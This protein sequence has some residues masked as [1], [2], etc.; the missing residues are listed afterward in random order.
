MLCVVEFKIIVNAFCLFGRT[1]VDCELN[2]VVMQWLN[3]VISFEFL[4]FLY[5][6]QTS[7][8][9]KKG[10]VTSTSS[11]S[12]T[13]SQLSSPP[14]PVQTS[15]ESCSIEEKRRERRQRRKALA[16]ANSAR[17][18]DDGAAA[19]DESLPPFHGFTPEYVQERTQ[20]TEEGI[21]RNKLI[22]ELLKRRDLTDKQL[23]SI[24]G[25]SKTSWLFGSW[26]GVFCY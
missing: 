16:A 13:D 5:K 26:V 15:V 19:G 21:R 17:A 23:K 20:M 1:S 7:R 10:R 14:A 8:R 24:L 6:M 18:A 12:S 9:S 25:S 4:M 11:Q 22:I 2:R 3:C